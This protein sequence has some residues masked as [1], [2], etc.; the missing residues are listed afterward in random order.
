MLIIFSLNEGLIKKKKKIIY[1][2]TCHIFLKY[3]FIIVHYIMQ[4]IYDCSNLH[5]KKRYTTTEKHF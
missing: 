5:L 2:T 1:S 4:Y 3:C